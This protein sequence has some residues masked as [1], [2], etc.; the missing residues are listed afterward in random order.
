MGTMRRFGAVT[1]TSGTA[2]SDA[3]DCG[4]FEAL[5][6][7][8]VPA[9]WTTADITLLASIPDGTT[10]AY[11]YGGP[12]GATEYRDGL[13]YADVWDT[14]PLVDV[15]FTMTVG[16]T[17]SKFLAIPVTLLQGAQFFK[18][19]SGTSG[20]PVNQAADRTLRVVTVAL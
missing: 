17:G 10:Q 2:V 13:T 7:I 11:T 12:G 4:E 15:E 18:I 14:S 1:I 19:R 3:Y 16:A 9:T 6:G 20:T 8:Q 5:V